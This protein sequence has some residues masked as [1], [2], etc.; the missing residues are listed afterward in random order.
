MWAI[1]SPSTSFQAATAV[2]LRVRIIRGSQ[3]KTV[4][5][6]PLRLKAT[7]SWNLPPDFV[8][9]EGTMSGTHVSNRQE[10]EDF[11]Y[12]LSPGRV[13]GLLLKAIDDETLVQVV[14]RMIEQLGK[15]QKEQ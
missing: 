12:V 2:G 4:R 8:L 1:S 7:G 6:L 15:G 13:L 5:T 11:L 9:G 3:P 14:N 10:V